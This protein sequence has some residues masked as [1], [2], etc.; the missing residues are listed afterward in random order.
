MQ[1]LPQSAARVGGIPF[2][3]VEWGSVIAGAVAALAVSFILLT[4]GA[5]VGLAAVSPWSLSSTGVTALGLGSAFW[6]LLVSLWSFA[7]GGYFAARLRHRWSD[8]S[9]TEIEFRDRA[10]GLLSWATA[11]TIA[12][13]VT[14]AVLT[15]SGRT[16]ATDNLIT[17]TAVDTIV[18]TTRPNLAPADTALR[19]EVSRTLASNMKS[20]SL[21]DAD[22][23]YL[24]GIVE[25][26]SGL[27]APES[28]KRV[29]DA[30]SQMKVATDR[31]RKAG[32][33][34]GFLVAATLLVGAAMAWWAAGV[35]GDHR[36]QG[37]IW[38]IFGRHAGGPTAIITR[39]E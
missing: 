23:A 15:P 18:R 19:G 13:I 25:A 26:R 12:A 36:D 32:I 28:A 39:S 34:M 10:H 6:I 20:P 37:T 24:T 31:A 22:R 29:T 1:E 9:K 4:F 11:V 27:A 14:T 21:S 38:H 3:Y 17:A 8:A 35:G 2:S 30:F 5:A 7:L 16:A 33:V